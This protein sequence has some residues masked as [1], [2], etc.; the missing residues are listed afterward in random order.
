ME[1]IRSNQMEIVTKQDTLGK[2]YAIYEHFSKGLNVACKRGCATCC[3]QDVTMTTLEG[4]RI[5]R[6]LIVSRKKELLRA[7]HHTAHSKRFQP[8][9]STNELAALC[10]KGEDPPEEHHDAS[11]GPCPFL[12]CGECLVYDDRPFGCR[13]FF[14]TQVCEVEGCAVAAPFLITVNTVFFQF[15][16]HVDSKGLFGNMT[17][18]ILFL[19]P[20]RRRSTYETLAAFDHEKRQDD[21]NHSRQLGRL[22]RNRAMPA[23]LA[24]PEHRQDLQPILKELGK[25]R[26]RPFRNR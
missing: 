20:E 26:I 1:M 22:A 15:I 24:P 9:L 11:P 10:L 21:A 18:V 2:I 25:I 7:V 23:L 16:E 3:T 14:S 19:E 4:Y 13:C 5:L 8:A 6:H 17:D 12:S